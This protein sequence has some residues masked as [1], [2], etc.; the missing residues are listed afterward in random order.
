MV[1]GRRANGSADCSREPDRKEVVNVDDISSKPQ[2]K[3][4]EMT[5]HIKKTF[6]LQIECK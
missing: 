5:K 4:N 3:A 2:S 1:G 6:F